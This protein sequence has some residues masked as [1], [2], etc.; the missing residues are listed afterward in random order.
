MKQR[1][2]AGLCAVAL[3]GLAGA[4]DAQGRPPA[5]VTLD[6]VRVEPLSQ[7]TPLISRIVALRA[8]P[9]TATVS[10]AVTAVVV[11]IGDRVAIGDPLAELDQEAIAFALSRAEAEVALAEASRDG[12]RADAALATQEL[13]RLRRL[14]NSAA[15]N[16]ARFEDAQSRAASAA[17]AAAEAEADIARAEADRGLT[18]LALE[19][20]VIRA[21]YAGVVT[22]K[23][24]S[25][26]AYVTPGVAVVSLLDDRALEI[27]APVPYAQIGGAAPGRTVRVEMPSGQSLTA[28]VRA[29]LPQEDSLTRTRIVRLRPDW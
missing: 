13:Q 24:L 25:S 10:A 20:T 23:H 27:E 7:T 15:F 3:I 14:R 19:N 2:F 9:V 5:P 1:L 28:V 16:Q 17:A 22:D 12:A 29:A 8:G 4:A 21:P 18:A 6:P 26:G 11:E